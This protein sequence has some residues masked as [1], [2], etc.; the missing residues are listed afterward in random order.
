MGQKCARQEL[1]WPP[2]KTPSPES[3]DQSPTAFRF[4]NL[5]CERTTRPERHADHHDPVIAPAS[6]GR[7]PPPQDT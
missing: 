5:V 4:L 6:A 7:A 3:I 2:P 1:L